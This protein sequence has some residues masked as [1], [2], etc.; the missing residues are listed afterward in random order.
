MEI[1]RKNGL[2]SDEDV[3]RTNNVIEGYKSKTEREININNAIL[4]CLK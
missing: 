3:V 2:I 4:N 1:H